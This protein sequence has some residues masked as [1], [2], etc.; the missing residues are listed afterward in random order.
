MRHGRGELKQSF[1]FLR[2]LGRHKSSIC[3]ASNSAPVARP[4][5]GRHAIG[6]SFLIRARRSE[7]PRHCLA[8][9]VDLPTASAIWFGNLP[10]VAHCHVPRQIRRCHSAVA[11]GLHAIPPFGLGL[12]PR[13]SA[14][15]RRSR[16]ESRVSPENSQFAGFVRPALSFPF[17][18]A[19]EP[20]ESLVLHLV[21]RRSA[22]R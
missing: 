16:P 18:I 1:P 12:S 6:M 19:H 2:R 3:E 10:S 21:G 15:L 9:L 4:S 8:R 20:S 22:P 13:R 5:T 7:S 11:A 17:A 14:R